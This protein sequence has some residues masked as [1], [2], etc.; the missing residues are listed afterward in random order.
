M[1]FHS[2]ID[3]L[4]FICLPSCKRNLLVPWTSWDSTK[5]QKDDNF[6]GVLKTL[7]FSTWTRFVILVVFAFL[8]SELELFPALVPLDPAG[9]GSSTIAL[10][11]HSRGR[12]GCAAGRPRKAAPTG[13][14]S[15]T[16]GWLPPGLPHWSALVTVGWSDV[17]SDIIVSRSTLVT[18]IRLQ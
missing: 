1:W 13:G 17:Y 5:N 6:D 10:N 14:A 3:L 9:T 8:P 18:M 7:A 11:A 12:R 2:L 4:V 16:G 15:A